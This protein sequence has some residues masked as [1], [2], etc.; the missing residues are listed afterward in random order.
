MEKS[1]IKDPHSWQ[2]RMKA[3]LGGELDETR[4]TKYWDGVMNDESKKERTLTWDEI[5]ERTEALL[6]DGYR[7]V[8]YSAITPKGDFSLSSST[9]DTKPNASNMFFEL[10]FD[11]N[12]FEQIY[13]LFGRY[14]N[15]FPD[16]FKKQD[17][18]EKYCSDHDIW[19]LEDIKTLGSARPIPV[20][21]ST[22][23]IDDTKE[24]REEFNVPENQRLLYHDTVAISSSVQG[25]RVGMRFMDIVDGYYLKYFGAE[26]ICYGLCTGEI[27]SNDKGM[28]SKGFHEKRGFGD[29]TEGE[30]PLKK[31]TDRYK[32]VQEKYDNKSPNAVNFMLHSYRG[33]R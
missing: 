11:K 26:N 12:E 20:G 25:N 9:T 8:K 1:N 31:W 4:M 13:D 22:F 27:N 24:G 29:W 17:D 5:D 6:K 10:K 2:G 7:I 23:C 28:L 16:Y 3:N 18:F 19:V 33:G 15:N 32:S 21:F 30:A 14:E